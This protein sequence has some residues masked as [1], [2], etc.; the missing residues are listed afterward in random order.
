MDTEH[1]EQNNLLLAQLQ[2]QYDDKMALFYDCQDRDEKRADEHYQT[3]NNFEIQRNDVLADLTLEY[4][5]ANGASGLATLLGQDDTN[6][7]LD[8]DENVFFSQSNLP[9]ECPW[10]NI[11]HLDVRAAISNIFSPLTEHLPQLITLLKNQCHALFGI[12]FKKNGWHLLYVLKGQKQ[13]YQYDSLVILAGGSPNASPIVNTRCEQYGWKIPE[14]LT[15]FYAVH[16][17]FG[18]VAGLD[19]SFVFDGNYNSEDQISDSS[20]I[21]PFIPWYGLDQETDDCHLSGDN[22]K[23]IS[24]R[25]EL[26]QNIDSDIYLVQRDSI[27]PTQKCNETLYWNDCGNIPSV[28]LLGFMDIGGDALCF[29]RAYEDH[30]DCA[31]LAWYHDTGSES[32]ELFFPIIDNRM[33]SHWKT[34]LCTSKHFFNLKERG[35]KGEFSAQ[36]ELSHTYRLGTGVRQNSK[37]AFSYLKMT[38]RQSTVEDKILLARMYEEGFGVSQN[39]KEAQVWY[40]SVAEQGNVYAQYKLGRVY[41]NNDQETQAI[42]WFELA[43]KQQHIKAANRLGRAYDSG[44]GVTES[45]E[46]AF[47]WYKIAADMGCMNSKLEAAMSYDYG[48]GTE[49]SFQDAFE[50]YTE[51]ANQ[52]SSSAQYKL[53]VMYENGDYIDQS[54]EQAFQW[55]LKSAENENENAQEKVGHMYFTGEGVT[56]SFSSAT[57]WFKQAYE[58]CGC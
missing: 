12:K 1:L 50:L 9:K 54:S 35:A 23:K 15:T 4:L 40:K 26:E 5:D 32:I 28:N 48:C 20:N 58:N 51:V 52:G 24:T 31:I 42:H 56:Q 3:A 10:H 7:A 29:A 6:P 46:L 22:K 17:G 19:H 2:K 36:V 57:Y 33:T 21:G 8:G 41:W 27:F 38:A 18:V 39:K 49:Q 44:Y 14:D 16:N 45:Q 25:D 30:T 13:A 37:K 47:Q 53:A 55:F 11:S 34:D 43:A